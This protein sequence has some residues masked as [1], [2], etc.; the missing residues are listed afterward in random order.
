MNILI[1]IG[2]VFIYG[3]LTLELFIVFLLTTIFTV[4]SLK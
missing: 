4:V 3:L 1:Y 2:D